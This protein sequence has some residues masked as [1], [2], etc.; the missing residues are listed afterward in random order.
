MV[1]RDRVENVVRIVLLTGA[2]AGPGALLLMERGTSAQYFSILIDAEIRCDP[3]LCFF[4][5]RSIV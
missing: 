1:G 4:D 2:G 5:E 3:A